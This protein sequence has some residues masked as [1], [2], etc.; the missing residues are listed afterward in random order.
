MF[1]LGYGNTVS[2]SSIAVI[3][4]VLIAVSRRKMHEGKKNNKA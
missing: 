1:F 4:I 2:R 3:G